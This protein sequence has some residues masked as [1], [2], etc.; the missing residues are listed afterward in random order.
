MLE[1]DQFTI[2]GRIHRLGVSLGQASGFT[3][4]ENRFEKEEEFLMKGPNIIRE[5]KLDV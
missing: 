1:T 4:L 2:N 5:K 3:R